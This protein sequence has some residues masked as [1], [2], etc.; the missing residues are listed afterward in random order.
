VEDTPLTKGWTS[1]SLTG[2][3]CGSSQDNVENYMEYSYCGKMFSN[4]QSMRMLAALTS[5]IAQRNQLITPANLAATGCD[6]PGPLCDVRIAHGRTEIC[7]GGTVTFTD[8]SFHNVTERVW[9][10]PG[11]EPSSSTSPSQVVTYNEPGWHAVSL[12]VSNGVNSLSRTEEHLVY[13]VENPGTPVPFFEGFEDME[14][15]PGNGWWANDRDGDGGFFV[16][17]AA[18]YSGSRSVMLMNGGPNIGKLDDLRSPALDLANASGLAISFRYAFARRNGYNNDRLRVYISMD[19]GVNWSLRK[20][21]RAGTGLTTAGTVTGNFVPQGPQDWDIAVVDVPNS[22]FHVGNLQLRFEFLGDAG[23]NLYLDDINIHGT[24]VGLVEQDAAV[25]AVIAPN[26][27]QENAQLIL[28][29]DQRSEVRIV[30]KD[31]LGREVASILEK[32][33]DRSEHK[34]F[35]PLA[36]LNAGLYFV[37]IQRG[38]E[39]TAL[40]LIKE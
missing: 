1:C 30:L 22:I 7:Q 10:F 15:L 21:L 38:S 27:A 20:Q 31:V 32:S 34:I 28:R 4:G 35:I 19:C 36:G 33:L 6:V 40:K 17:S 29:L 26:P 12:T 9:S 37:E 14:T 39:R 24:P 2:A 5:T 25:S 11:G 18:A 13:V 23:N 16:T 3:S 8:Q